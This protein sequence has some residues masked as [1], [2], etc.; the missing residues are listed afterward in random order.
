MQPPHVPPTPLRSSRAAA[1][2]RA[3]ILPSMLLSIAAVLLAACGGGGSASGPATEGANTS[4]G[5][6]AVT[7]DGL[8]DATDVTVSAGANA[9]A[10][11]SDGAAAVTTGS[12]AATT[13]GSSAESSG[14]ATPAS[15]TT[16][17]SAEA[18]IGSPS[19]S[20]PIGALRSGEGTYHVGTDGS[21]ACEY[22][23]SPDNLMVAAINGPEYLASA[24]CGTFIRATGP[25]GTVTVRIVDYCPECKAGDIDFSVEAFAKIATAPPGRIPIS[26][27]VVPGDIDGPIR[28]RYREGSSRSW[29]AIQVRN[30][31]LP[32]TKLEVL[33]NGES[34]WRDAPRQSWNYFV[35]QGKV[36]SGPIRVRV[37][38]IDGQTLEEILPEPQGALEIDGRGQF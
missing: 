11:P 13:P 28:L 33:P 15:P 16:P 8:E 36:A 26:W 7:A 6:S 4:A 5:A 38:A 3:A 23:A 32:I 31:R 37:T 1:T 12:S 35:V 27:Q 34:D 10:A 9:Q 17:D 19:N 14:T 18:P 25:K 30:H 21:G 20:A 24:A 29:V 22:G 2:R